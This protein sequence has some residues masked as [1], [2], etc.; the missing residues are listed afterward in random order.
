MQNVFLI[1]VDHLIQHGGF[2]DNRKKTAIAEFK[3]HLYEV[4]TKYNISLIAEEFNEVALSK[5]NTDYCTCR[6][7]ARE[8][9][10]GHLFCDPTPDERKLLA[11]ETDNQRENVWL[12]RLENIKHMNILFICGSTHLET[13]ARLLRSH[14]IQSRILSNKWGFNYIGQGEVEY[15]Q[16]SCDSTHEA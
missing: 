8:L 6:E 10:I 11:I 5:S 1:G 7:V 15:F 13:F 3:V 9:Q 14:G 16:S 12:K 2:L 4:V